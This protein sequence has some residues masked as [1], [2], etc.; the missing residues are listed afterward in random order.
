MK[1][2][3]KKMRIETERLIIRPYKR[4]D[5]NECFRL[6]Q[7]D[8]LFDYLDM[9]VM[10]FEEYQGLFS[11]LIDSYKKDFN[12]DFKYS[13]NITLK[14]TGAHVGWCGIGVLDYDNQYKEIYYLIGKEYWGNGY[15][16][17][18][19]TALLEFGFNVIGLSEIV[20]LCK[21][22]NKASKNVIE[23]MGLSFKYIVEGLPQEHDYYNGELY[24]SLTK[25]E[26]LSNSK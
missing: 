16:K 13:F 1:R 22:E 2:I 14:E 26:Y 7:D 19:S 6:M 23:N 4:E 20:A 25:R 8:E 5:L 24:F 17:E 15:A 3:D 21:Q 9:E 18:A 10:T 11:W 12:D